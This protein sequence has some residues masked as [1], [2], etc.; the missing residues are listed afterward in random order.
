MA[1]AAVTRIYELQVRLAQDSLRALQQI[2]QH[3][4]KVESA[5][6]AAKEALTGFATG[7]VSVFSIGA[8]VSKLFDVAKAMDDIGDAA[9]RAQVGVVEFSTLAEALNLADVPREA[10]ERGFKALGQSIAE[11]G[12]EGS[13]ADRIFKAIGV[14][15]TGKP[16]SEVLKDIAAAFTAIED[17]VARGNV[18]IELFGK[19]G[20]DMVPALAQGREGI[21]ALEARVRELGGTLTEDGAKAAGDFDRATKEARI[22]VDSLFRSINEG[23]LPRLTDIINAFTQGSERGD[24]LARTGKYLGEILA[25][26]AQVANVVSTAVGGFTNYLGGLGAAAYDLVNGNFADIPKVFA[27]VDERNRRLREEFNR[28]RE[29]ISRGTPA[30]KD[31]A[32]AASASAV[33]QKALANALSDVT[34]RAKGK[35]KA[36]ADDTRGMRQWLDMRREWLAS[37]DERDEV[38]A[39]SRMS[40]E[41]IAAYVKQ[42][43]QVLGLDQPFQELR[44]NIDDTSKSVDRIVSAIQ[45]YGE[46]ISRTLADVVIGGKDAK[47]TWEDFASSFVRNIT[48]MITQVLVFQPL[49][50]SIAKAVRGL[51]LFGGESLSPA[52]VPFLPSAHGN[53]FHGGAVTPFASGGVLTRPT[54]FPMASGGVGLAGEA[55][56]EAIM[57]LARTPSGDLGVKSA[58][59]PVNVYIENR[60]SAQVGQVKQT[61]GPN[62]ERQIRMVIEDV[63]HAGIARGAFDSALA[64]AYGVTRQGRR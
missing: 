47:A 37:W 51:N 17:P 30:V 63:V 8:G 53:V 58:P 38:A 2:Q 3:A 40:D 56:W 64:G 32:A 7:L 60:S 41:K 49:V 14:D 50:D 59:A 16:K 27:D 36:I 6:G 11:A 9:E 1:E 42:A 39:A 61:T 57:P 19:A 28:T 31:N 12:K 20:L 22:A 29:A 46:D 45:G 4:G 34:E 52:G 18:A 13:Q 44:T 25:G 26:V 21:D 10:L 35:T 15:P 5:L 48:A 62:G 54:L 23:L 24:E 33:D 55:G 43:D